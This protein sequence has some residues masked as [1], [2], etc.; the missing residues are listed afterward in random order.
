MSAFMTC[1]SLSSLD[2]TLH[3]LFTGWVS[4][5]AEPV[6]LARGGGHWPL[7]SSSSLHRSFSSS[8]PACGSGLQRGQSL[9][10]LLCAGL[11]G[12]ALPPAP[13]SPDI[14]EPGQPGLHSET[15]SQQNRTLTPTLLFSGSRLL[16][17]CPGCNWTS[18]NALYLEYLPPPTSASRE[19]VAPVTL[20]PA[21]REWSFRVSPRKSATVNWS[22]FHAHSR[23]FLCPCRAGRAGVPWPPGDGRHLSKCGPASPSCLSR[24]SSRSQDRS[25]RCFSTWGDIW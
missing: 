9:A 10:E 12:W 20:R 1:L 13:W 24:R 6:L 2:L 3:R 15:P 16:V 19:Q 21:L 4:S 22:F 7:S 25:L 14:P 23:R 8:S 18:R 17:R 5:A 11:P